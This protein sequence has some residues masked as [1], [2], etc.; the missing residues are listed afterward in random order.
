VRCHHF[1]N[2]NT[3]RKIEELGGEAVLPPFEEWLNYIAWERRDES[4]RGR[5]WGVLFKE[6]VVGQV[7]RRDKNRILGLFRG[8]LRGRLH[9]RPTAE[10]L[11]R[12]SPYIH[13]SIRGEACLSMGRAVEYAEEDFAGVVNIAPFGCLPSTIVASLTRKFR[14]NHRGIPWL[15][16]YFD[17]TQQTGTQTRLEAFMAQA[18]D[19]AQGRRK[20]RHQTK[21]VG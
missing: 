10:I 13:E 6:L 14:K 18:G 5:R 21:T 1:A 2:E 9:E 11:E 20:R 12:A 15:D 16:M 4:R 7:Q 8:H 19:Y 3:V 17:G